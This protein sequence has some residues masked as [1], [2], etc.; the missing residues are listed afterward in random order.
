MMHLTGMT[1]ITGM[2][3]EITWMLKD[4][5]GMMGK[6]WD[7]DSDDWDNKGG[8]LAYSTGILGQDSAPSRFGLRFQPPTQGEVSILVT[9][10]SC[11]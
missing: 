4:I 5:T 9:L 1:G 6:N 2:R 8:N 7:G 3:M 11:K 10:L